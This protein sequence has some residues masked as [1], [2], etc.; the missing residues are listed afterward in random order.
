MRIR[1]FIGMLLIAFTILGTE[2]C[3]KGP[4]TSKKNNKKIKSGKPMPC[5]LKD[6]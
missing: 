5:P 6:C 4:S 1:N 3:R 2:G